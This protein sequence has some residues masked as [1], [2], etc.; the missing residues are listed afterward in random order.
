MAGLF[1]VAAERKTMAGGSPIASG[2]AHRRDRIR[3]ARRRLQPWKSSNC[4]IASALPH[5]GREALRQLSSSG[6]VEMRA[7]ARPGRCTDDA[8]AHHGRSRS[9][10]RSEAMCV[11]LAT[12]RM[13]PLERSD[14]IELH[15]GSLRWSKR[16]T[17][18]PTMLSTGNRRRHLP[19]DAQRI[20]CEQAQH[21]RS[22]LSAFRRTRCGRATAFVGL[23]MST[24]PSCRRSPKVM[25][26]RLRAECVRIC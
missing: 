15:D 1:K 24:S 17:S 4:P 16:V 13:T 2:R 20:S 25:A 21:V 9:A 14:L 23:G 19:C 6:L 10:P 12:Y 11:R 18:M 5:A 8:G 22:R 26:I 3:R 7:A